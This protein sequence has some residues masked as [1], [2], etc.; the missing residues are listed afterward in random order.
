MRCP[1][2]QG[3]TLKIEVVFRAFVTAIFHSS[4]RFELSQPVSMQ[5]SWTDDSPCICE[6]CHWAGRVA[7]AVAE[8]EKQDPDSLE[9]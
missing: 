9:E 6:A 3:Q 5:S 8:S 7:E 1:N 2:C 4:D